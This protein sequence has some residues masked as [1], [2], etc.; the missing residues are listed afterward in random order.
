MRRRSIKRR[1]IEVS[2]RPLDALAV[3]LQHFTD[4]HSPLWKDLVFYKHSIAGVYTQDE[5]DFVSNQLG[6]IDEV[7]SAV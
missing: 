1:G 7:Q 5:I 6:N 4:M 2:G 3:L